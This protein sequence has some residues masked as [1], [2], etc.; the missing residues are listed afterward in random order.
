LLDDNGVSVH[1]SGKPVRLVGHALDDAT[2]LCALAPQPGA[3]PDDATPFSAF[4]PP[5]PSP[6]DGG[7]VA[8]PLERGPVLVTYTPRARLATMRFA[9]ARQP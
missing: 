6:D 9:A 7:R 8:P 2:W 1:L 3:V 5:V 4:A